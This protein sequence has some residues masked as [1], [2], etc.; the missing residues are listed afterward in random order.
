MTS[1]STRA[2]IVA[3]TAIFF[4]SLAALRG[5]A[6]TAEGDDLL[7]GH[8]RP[9]YENVEDIDAMAAALRKSLAGQESYSYSRGWWS[10]GL[11]SA[12]NHKIHERIYLRPGR[13]A[14]DPTA[15]FF[16]YE[17][18]DEHLDNVSGHLY[19]Y[20]AQGAKLLHSSGKYNNVY[21]G[22]DLRGGGSGEESLDL[23][24]V[25]HK[26][27]NFPLHPDRKGDERDYMRR[28]SIRSLPKLSRAENNDAGDS[29]GQFAFED[30]YGPGSRWIRRAV[31]THDG[32]LVVADEYVGGKALGDD[33]VAGPVWHLAVPDVGGKEA[34]DARNLAMQDENW[35]DGPAF[36]H[37]WWQKEKIRLLLCIH[38]DGAMK[39]GKVRQQHSQDTNPNITCFGWRPIQ[40]EKTERLLSVLVPHTQREK[41]RSLA[42]ALETRVTESGDCTARINGTNITIKAS[43]T[44]AVL[45]EEK[46]Q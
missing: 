26:R 37:A 31:L 13:V 34:D 38:Q 23:L 22:T 40:H 16:L 45:R 11:L 28:G 14:G 43:G 29:F 33:Y 9:S 24:L 17:K 20:S 2:R 4:F 35:F 27:H 3:N 21:S 44:W 10:I 15:A 1:I 30:Y 6:Q 25:M 8:P 39:F 5:L 7:T 12:T 18:K 41:P 36:A 46:E 32:Y 19:E 42:A